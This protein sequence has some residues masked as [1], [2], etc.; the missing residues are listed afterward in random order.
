MKNLVEKDGAF[1]LRLIPPGKKKL[2]FFGPTKKY[3]WIGYPVFWEEM[4][5]EERDKLY[6]VYQEEGLEALHDAVTFLDK[7]VW[8]HRRLRRNESSFKNGR[9]LMEER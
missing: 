4:S 7:S 8:V 2:P 3:L 9:N 5:E 1:T 6:E